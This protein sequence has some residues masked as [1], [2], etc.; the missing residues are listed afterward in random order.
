M[1]SY[2]AGQEHLPV[3]F[4]E[5]LE[6]LR[7]RPGGVYLDGTLGEGGHAEG[8]LMA[9]PD[10][11]IIGLDQD[12]SVLDLA[13]KR[14]EP[15]ADRVSAFNL[16]FRFMD[17]ALAE[18]GMPAVDGIVL[19]LGVSSRQ[20]DHSERGFSFL[21]DGP[22][23]MRMDPS[24]DLTAAEV[25]NSYDERDLRRII[26]RFGEEKQA[27]RIAAAIVRERDRGP[28]TSTGRLAE[29]VEGASDRGRSR[30]IHPAT[31]TF[32]ALRIEVNDELNALTEALPLGVGLLEDGGRMA[33]ISFH[34]LEDRIVKRA[35]RELADPCRCPRDLPVCACGEVSRGKVIT[36]KPVRPTQGEIDENPRSRSARLRVL[37]GQRDESGSGNQGRVRRLIGRGL[38][39][40]SVPLRRGGGG[41]GNHL[42]HRVARGGLHRPW[43]RD[44]STGEA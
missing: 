22:L 15:Y 5:V 24:R 39:G 6:G 20:L 33:V 1:T 42:P 18:L 32:Q 12:P 31:R 27:S 23:D 30:R 38:Q 9:Y 21:R 19:D 37:R 29:I 28:I 40:R 16:N 13:G 11:R 14:L 41:R 7:L 8:V 34:S 10:T 4:R 36:R 25:V 44:P 2:R 3:L 43:L 35:F 26:F 17:R